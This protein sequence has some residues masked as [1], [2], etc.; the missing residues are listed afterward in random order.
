M[1]QIRKALVAVDQNE[2]G[3]MSILAP[4]LSEDTGSRSNYRVDWVPEDS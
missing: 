3:G 4:D 1:S 2:N